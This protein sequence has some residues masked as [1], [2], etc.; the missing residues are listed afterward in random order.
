MNIIKN[1]I[2]KHKLKQELRI[3]EDTLKQNGY[4][5]EMEKL[6]KLIYQPDS[7]AS[8]LFKIKRKYCP[9]LSRKEYIE[10]QLKQLSNKQLP[11]NTS[12]QLTK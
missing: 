9:L 10:K 1:L 2:K 3:I 5:T 4:Y 7:Y 6:N 8:L 12:N 11:N